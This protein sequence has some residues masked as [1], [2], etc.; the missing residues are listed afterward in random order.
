MSSQENML[1]QRHGE[2]AG[3][4]TCIDLSTTYGS[5]EVNARQ[6]TSED[7]ERRKYRH[8]HAHHFGQKWVRKNGACRKEKGLEF[9]KSKATQP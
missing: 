7:G 2:F 1:R 9:Q 8:A 3:I 5:G 4:L 6:D